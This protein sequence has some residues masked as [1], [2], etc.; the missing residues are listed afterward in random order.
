MSATCT[1]LL[2]YLM[3]PRNKQPGPKKNIFRT[4]KQR[5]AVHGTE[6]WRV[7]EIYALDSN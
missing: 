1:S 7:I 5:I 6:Q 4:A 2:I 3:V